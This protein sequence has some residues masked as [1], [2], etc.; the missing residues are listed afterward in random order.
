MVVWIVLLARHYLCPGGPALYARRQKTLMDAWVRGGTTREGAQGMG[1]ETPVQEVTPRRILL[2]ED[3]PDIRVSME[4]ILKEEGFGIVA[5]SNGRDALTKL[6]SMTA[7]D[8]IILD[9]MMP[10]MDGWQFRIQ[11]K[12]DPVLAQIPVI[13]ISADASFKAAAID[14]A[15]YL[16]KP[17]DH[18]SLMGAI[19]RVLIAFER[20]KLHLRLSEVDSRSRTLE[21]MERLKSAFVSN[22][23]HE[24]RTPLNA[25]LSLSQLMRDG[26]AGPITSEQ[27]RYLDVIQRSGRSVLNL[28][29]DIMDLANL[30]TGHLEVRSE[31]LSA[32]DAIDVVLTALRPLAD[33][34][35][36]G[37][38][39]DVPA[40]LPA[41]RADGHRL[42]QVLT[43]L[44]G[45]AIK[46]TEF[47]TIKIVGERRGDVV[48]ISVSDTGIGIPENAIP[49]IFQGFYQVDHRLGR[50]HQGAGIGLTLVDR[51]VRLMGGELTVRSIV[52]AGSTFTFT[53]PVVT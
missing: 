3:D 4:S 2:V 44:L 23:S 38:V 5:C 47:G 43:H 12:N 26:S 18:A 48:A 24:I 33:L 7:P 9:L 41:L 28:L 20:R 6:G 40:T 36:L 1:Q 52:G 29:S 8:L 10:V 19:E 31:Q 37:V 39:I 30:E 51:L 14:A 34:K 27:E 17:F 46:F 53:L 49:R 15:A 35:K 22:L 11:Q 25:V 50:R 45:N 13:A 16:N 21:E 32:S 42:G